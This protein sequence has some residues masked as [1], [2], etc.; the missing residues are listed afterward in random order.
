MA[1]LQQHAVNHRLHADLAQVSLVHLLAR[2]RLFLLG[3]LSLPAELALQPLVLA[4]GGVQA[5]RL[6]HKLLLLAAA[7]VVDE[8]AGEDLFDLLDRQAL[9]VSLGADVGQ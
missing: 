7:L 1:A 5:P 2:G 4:V 3:R 8:V 6:L 9:D